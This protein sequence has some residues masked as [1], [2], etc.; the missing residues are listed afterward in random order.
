MQALLSAGFTRVGA[1][2]GNFALAAVA[3]DGEATEQE[4]QLL[5]QRRL[6]T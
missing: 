2:R 4:V 3:M 1:R 6:S 5:I